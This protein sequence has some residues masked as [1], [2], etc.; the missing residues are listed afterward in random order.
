MKFGD[1]IANSYTSDD[2]PYHVLMFTHKCAGY[3]HCIA[4]DG[5]SLKFDSQ[6]QEKD[7][8]LSIIGCINLDNWP[9]VI[10]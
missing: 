3:I 9:V 2:N 7:K 10:K 4:R 8:F 6:A 1:L 5:R